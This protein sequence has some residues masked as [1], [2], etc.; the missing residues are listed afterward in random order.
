MFE[1]VL[2]ER[3]AENIVS[4]T[5]K[6]PLIV[7]KVK[8][9][10]FVI[11]RLDK[12]GERIPLT[13]VSIDASDNTIRI[14]VQE[15]GKTTM[16]FGKLRVGDAIRDIVGPLGNATD[17]K[18][19]GHVLV[20][21]G[22]VGLAEAYPV[23]QAFKKAKNKVT[24]IIGAQN[25]D[26]LILEDALKRVCDVLHICTDDGSKG[27]KGFVTE[28]LNDLLASDDPIDLVYTVGPPIMMKKVAEL[29]LP[30]N[31][32]TIASLNTTMVDGTGMCGACR[33][34]VN[35]ETKFACIDG[36]EFDAHKI[37]FPELLERQ[38]LYQEKERLSLQKYL[39]E[40]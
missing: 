7:K 14:I 1:V 11:L 5:I 18:K 10:Q 17:V 29:T 2:R 19:Y 4:L 30:H 21:G 6:A 36:P 25:K 26:L 9:G 38:K 28:V 8:A 35:G 37:D 27:R 22:G 31:I 40:K 15:T 39:R 16:K 34:T 13:V 23:T 3:L 33:V 24:V 32:H 12:R 20:V